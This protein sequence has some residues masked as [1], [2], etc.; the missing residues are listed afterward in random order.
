MKSI[1]LQ[2]G[3]SRPMMDGISSFFPS[4]R[5][6]SK[7]AITNTHEYLLQ[8]VY[9]APQVASKTT[10]HLASNYIHSLHFFHPHALQ[11]R[12]PNPNFPLLALLAEQRHSYPILCLCRV[13]AYPFHHEW[14]HKFDHDVGLGGW[15]NP[16][17]MMCGFFHRWERADMY[18]G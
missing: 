16:P 2:R 14:I 18:I 11:N 7:T 10:Q 6:K 17:Q 3:L 1:R 9:L 5:R 8:R 15:I 12:V 4:R 13:V